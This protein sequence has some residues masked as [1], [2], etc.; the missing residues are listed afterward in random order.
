M[1]ASKSTYVLL[2]AATAAVLVTGFCLLGR[3]CGPR[4]MGAPRLCVPPVATAGALAEPVVVVVVVVVGVGVAPE[5]DE[6]ARARRI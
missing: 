1:Y 4:M 6:G 3:C 5:F 2:A